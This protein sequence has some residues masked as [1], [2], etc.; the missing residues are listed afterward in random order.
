MRRVALVAIALTC[1]VTCGLEV[2]S[3]SLQLP[4]LPP[5]PGPPPPPTRP[6]P[7][8]QT[9]SDRI[10]LLKELEAAEAHWILHR[11][12]TYQLT[13]SFHCYCPPTPRSAP[14]VSRVAGN[15]VI[16]STGEDGPASLPPMQTV[17]SLFSKARDALAGDAYEVEVMFD[18]QLRYPT[19][20]GID[21]IR[22]GVDD[23]SSWVAVLKAL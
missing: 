15:I 17:E 11:P 19:R 5:P 8:P 14:L 1:L 18:P 12:R 23:E 20:I 6:A 3:R 4:P 13:V 7:K 10:E 2:P 22:E 16:R 21:P 9:R